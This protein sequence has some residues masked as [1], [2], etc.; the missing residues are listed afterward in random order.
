MERGRRAGAFRL[1]AC[2]FLA[3]M[4]GAGAPSP[5]YR[6]Y[7]QVWGFSPS[8]VA[9]VFVAYVVA[10]V[11]ALLT[12]GDLSDRLGRRRVLVVSLIVLAGSML[13]F[14]G[15]QGLSA[16]IVARGV[17]G[18]ATG[19]ATGAFSAAVIELQPP[20]RAQRGSFVT[21][22][23]PT[24]GPGTGALAS[25]ILVEFLPWPR[26]TAYLVLAAGYLVVAVA[27]ARIPAESLDL[28]RTA[29]SG[30]GLRLELPTDFRP[31]FV[32]IA[33]TL[34]AAW[35]VGGLFLA[36]APSFMPVVF[37]VDNAVAAAA[38][39]FVLLGAGATAASLLQRTSASVTRTMIACGGLAFGSAILVLGVAARNLPVFLVGCLLTGIAFGA[40][41]FLAM[42]MLSRS[43]PARSRSGVLS[44]IFV[45]N[46]AAFAA[47]P[48]LA[49]VCAT[50][51]G[52]PVTL[53]VYLCA[54]GLL[55]I[56]A[57]LALFLGGRRHG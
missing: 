17:Q 57:A 5:V 47:P 25:A 23:A 22:V 31:V 11:L 21:S 34:V 4:A 53:L 40:G 36:L 19:A 7:Q 41:F 37:A 16:L 33:P 35:S 44:T 43:I 29:R 55:A 9:L 50:R 48:L 56:A 3:M 2:G 15:A 1:V 42:A 27:I 32:R 52:F 54:T 10:L 45:L 51:F 38:T 20:D 49:G 13:M 26:Q 14:A 8:T 39:I 30:A 12:L 28:R 24:L 46:Y 6:V 18:L